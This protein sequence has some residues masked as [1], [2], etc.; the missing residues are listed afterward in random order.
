[1]CNIELGMFGKVQESYVMFVD[2][3][4][5]SVFLRLFI[6]CTIYDPVAWRASA[7]V[8]GFV[9]DYGRIVNKRRTVSMSESV[10]DVLFLECLFGFLY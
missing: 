10:I 6:N 9:Y 2:I 3:V 1:M 8:D 7:L 4:Y 5:H